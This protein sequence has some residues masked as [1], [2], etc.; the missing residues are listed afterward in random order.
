MFKNL[1]CYVAKMMSAVA[2]TGEMVRHFNGVR[3]SN[4][5]AARIE[6][7]DEFLSTRKHNC[8]CS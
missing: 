8:C 3:T 6:S 2:T 4:D 5:L 1:L 7:W